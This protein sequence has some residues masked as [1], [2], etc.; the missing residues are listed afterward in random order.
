M[1]GRY[2]AAMNTYGHVLPGSHRLYR[3]SDVSKKGKER[4]KWMDWYQAHGQN[5]RLTCRHFGLSP[6]VFYRWKNRYKPRDLSSLEDDQGT[7]R[8]KKVRQPEAPKEIVQVVKNLRER[9]PRWGKKK[10]WKLM[11]EDGIETSVSTVGRTLNRL[12]AM[13]RLKEPAIVTARLEGIQRQRNHK[14]PYAVRKPW[15]FQ[16]GKPGDLIQIDTVYVYTV[17][18]NQR[19]QFTACDCISKHTARTAATSKASRSAKEIFRAMDKR[20]PFPVKAIQVDGGSEFMAEFETACEKRG[21]T[22]Y[23]LPPRSP[24][25]NGMVE[26][27]QR[28]SKEEIYDIQPVPFV[29]AEHNQLLAKED[30]I[31]NHI[32]PHDALSLMTPDAYYQLNYSIS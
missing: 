7:R 28:T 4:L 2:D 16:T 8:P 30:H 9:Y 1:R 31:Y 27:M 32:R 23:I 26:R 18:G 12:R 19:Y 29:I 17:D 3:L 5:A 20:F 6:D 24:K 25:L 13:G 10:L 21:I 22:L 11:A 15:G 14:R